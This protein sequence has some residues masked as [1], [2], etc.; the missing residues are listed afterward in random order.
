VDVLL[1]IL[2]ER[3]STLTAAYRAGNPQGTVVSCRSF[4]EAQ[5]WLAG[6]LG[7]EDVVLVE[8]D[9]PDLYEKKLSL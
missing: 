6:K 1:A 4:S 7:P 8:N 3:I 2:P 5:A 9:L